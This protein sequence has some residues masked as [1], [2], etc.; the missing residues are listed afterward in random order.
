[1]ILYL[2]LLQ[3]HAF[4]ITVSLSNS[5]ISTWDTSPVAIVNNAVINI[6]IKLSTQ[7]PGVNSLVIY[8]K[9]ELWQTL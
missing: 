6:S 7:I 4:L 8:P 9:V 2:S 5:Y 1:M 3:Y